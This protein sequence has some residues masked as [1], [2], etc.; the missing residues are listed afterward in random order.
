MQTKKF[1]QSWNKKLGN[2]RIRG[3][4]SGLPVKGSEQSGDQVY[5]GDLSVVGEMYVVLYLSHLWGLEE[6]IGWGNFK[7]IMWVASHK[8]MGPIFLKRGGVDPSKHN[9]KILIW[10]LE[11]G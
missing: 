10:Q 3:H 7:F 2:P 8:E 9:V 5:L 6:L 4:F 1:K 11:E